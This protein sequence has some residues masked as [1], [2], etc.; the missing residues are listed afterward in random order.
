MGFCMR[1]DVV[2]HGERKTDGSFE[3]YAGERRLEPSRAIEAY[4]TGGP[5]DFGWGYA[6]GGSRLLATGILNDFLFGDAAEANR[7]HALF[8]DRFV[9]NWHPDEGWTLPG[10]QIEAFVTEMGK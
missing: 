1:T 8:A 2:Y 3:V 4:G 7:L 5:R 6:G 9:E 10:I